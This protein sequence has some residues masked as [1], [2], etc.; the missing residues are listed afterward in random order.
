MPADGADNDILNPLLDELDIKAE[1]QHASERSDDY[2]VCQRRH[3]RHPFRATCLV[4]FLSVG[5]STVSELPGR[6]RNLSR[7]GV[8]F[9]VR[10][11]FAV[12][13]VVELEIRPP[14][15]HPMYLGGLVTFCRY[16]GRGFHEVG[17]SLKAAQSEP[18]FSTSPAA[19]M[20]SLDWLRTAKPFQY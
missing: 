4:R 8:G 19:A 20:E 2:W 7:S 17:L 6:T 5:S 15:R 10:R 1:R 11:V 16:A 14:Q 13:E 3:P 9:L 12:G 18:V